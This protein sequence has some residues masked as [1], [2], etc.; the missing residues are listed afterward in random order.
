MFYRIL[1]I[2][3]FVST[4]IVGWSTHILGGEMY[5]EHQGG[6]SYKI[7]LKVYRDC[8]TAIFPYED[9]AEINL[10]EING[11]NY[12]QN[13]L[14]LTI[15]EIRDLNLVTSNSCDSVPTG[16][17]YRLVIYETII[18]IPLSPEGYILSY[19]R[20]CRTGA[21]SNL[22]G[23]NS[24]GTTVTT[25][26]PGTNI[27]TTPNSN[28]ILGAEPEVF[29][30][31]NTNF[32]F[33]LGAT[34][35]DGDSLVYLLADPI[36]GTYDVNQAP[37]FNSVNFSG[38][39]SASNPLGG[40][41]SVS[42]NSQT[43]MLS[44]NPQILG[45]FQFGVQVLEYRDGVLIGSTIRDFFFKVMAC[46]SVNYNA[47]IREQVNLNDFVSYCQGLE[48]NFINESDFGNEYLWDFGVANS[49]LDSSSLMNPTFSFPESGTY[50]VQLI[51]NPGYLCADTATATYIVN[52]IV[53]LEIVSDSVQ[54][55][56]NN[57]FDFSVQ[58]IP[59]T[60]TIYNWE[61]GNDAS[62]PFS[63]DSLVNGI[64]YQNSGFFPVQLYLEDNYCQ[65]TLFDTVIVMEENLINLAFT[66]SDELACAPYIV[67]F[68]NLSSGTGNVQ[69]IWDFGNGLN[70]NEINPSTNFTIPGDYDITLM[71]IS[72]S[73]CLDTAI[74]TYSDYIS[75]FPSPIA[76]I[77]V[78]RNVATP[79]DPIIEFYNQSINYSSFL[80][81]IEGQTSD[82][83]PYAHSFINSGYH[84]PYV[85]A[86]NDFGC[87][88]TARIQIFIDGEET[89]FI[90]NAFTPNGDG[91]N[92]Q[93]RF[94]AF[95]LKDFELLIFNR[96]G[97]M[98]F[99]TN[100]LDD[101]WDGKYKGEI[102]QDGVY[103]YQISYTNLKTLPE[104][105]RGTI[106]IL[107]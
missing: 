100:Q 80:F 37:P 38:G 69:Y 4:Q 83:D 10:F 6:T 107:K 15:S 94:S 75:V 7:T 34:D 51:V 18:D 49:S 88:D 91:K 104:V 72:D 22:Q 57:N 13:S 47:I 105:K 35:V 9:P 33:D 20:C 85:V 58:G 21:V 87:T 101:Y 92:D 46:P 23:A 54:C 86:S 61:F 77:D 8:E 41:S 3:C 11:N 16:S 64:V 14:F 73:G 32:N 12:I 43:G 95:D 62:I 50:E 67:Q 56:T 39:Y 53:D 106:T 45:M 90:P 28:P 19:T 89:V 1:L 25:T 74:I 29:L 59:N 40:N 71:A 97:K 93:L 99:K 81:H 65:D 98:V 27:I 24:T 84:Y 68:E 31:V 48:V 17:C 36:N 5:Y 26:I 70:S 63:S 102:V 2:V 60:G 42:I 44:L 96:Q 79:Y 103:I 78:N 55:I 30:C 66:K 52:E 76:G 82:M